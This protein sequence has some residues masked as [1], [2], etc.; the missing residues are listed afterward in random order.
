MTSARIPRQVPIAV[1]GIA[2]FMPGSTDAGGFWRNILA[3][4]DLIDRR[5]RRAAGSSRTTT[6]PT[7]AA[8]DKTYGRRGAFL[9]EVDFDP[10]ALRHPAGQPA[11]HRHDASCWR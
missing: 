5:A 1:V 8:P 4:R 11:G 9:P 7:R 6:T 3:G 10:L 2:A